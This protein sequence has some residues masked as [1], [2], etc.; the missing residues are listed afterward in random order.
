MTPLFNWVIGCVWDILCK[1]VLKQLTVSLYEFKEVQGR[2]NRTHQ[3]SS[4]MV[5]KIFM[6]LEN[7]SPKCA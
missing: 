3:K 5:L 6:N 2:A 7:E 1:L 4:L